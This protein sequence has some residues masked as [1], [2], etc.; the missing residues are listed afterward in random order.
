MTTEKREDN[1]AAGGAAAVWSSLRHTSAKSGLLRG[2]KALLRINQED[3][4]DCPGC[5][6]PDPEHRSTVEFCENGAKAVAHEADIR[7]V[8]AA[9][10]AKHSIT[11]LRA[12]TDFWLEDQGRLVEPVIRRVG[13][14]HYQPVTWE[15]AFA[16]IADHLTGLEHPDQAIFYTSGRASNEAAF[17]YQLLTRQLGTNNLPDCS[18]MCHESSGRGLMRTLGVGKGTVQLEDFDHA[19]MIFVVGQN[20]GT[21]HPRMLSTLREASKRGCQIISINPLRERALVRFSHPQKPL[22]FLGASTPIASQHVAVRIGGDLAL[23]KGICKHVLLLDEQAGG[24]IVDR[25]FINQHTEGFAQFA[26]SLRNISDDD[27]VNGSGVS[28]DIIKGLAASYAKAK[29]VIICWAMGITQHRHA[30]GSVREIVNLLLLRGNLGRQGAG[31][32]PVRGHSNVQGDRTMGIYEAPSEVFLQ[33]MESGTQIPMPRHHG[34]D[35]VGAV[36]A[37]EQ[38]KANFFMSLGGNFAAAMSDSPRIFSALESCVLTV[39]VATKLNRT[40]TTAGQTS[41]ILPC[42]GRTE[43]DVQKEKKQ[44]VTVEN[45]MGVVHLSQGSLKPA[46]DQLRSEPWIVAMLGH[47][48]QALL[49]KRAVMDAAQGR[50]NKKIS[51]YPNAYAVP[52]SAF[53]DDYDL[54]RTWI[55]KSIAGFDDFNKRVRDPHGLLLDNAARR[56]VFNNGIGKALFTVQEIPKLD[57]AAGHL[58]L[59][60]LRSHDQFNTTIYGMHDRYRDVYARRDVIFLHADDM[61]ERGLVNEQRVAVISYFA[62]Q[63]RRIDGYACIPYDI[64]KGSAAMYFPEANPLVPLESVAEESGTPTS[65][66]VEISLVPL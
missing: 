4:F 2:T 28:L 12:Q 7:K 52:W 46:S 45:S 39:H 13:D 19:D 10:F 31:A 51:Q 38:G 40:H 44:F 17:L 36:Q 6:W 56:L 9:F 63:E 49:Q 25:D 65:K 60:T 1:R 26:E 15:Q 54:I 8:D 33:K 3:G 50:Q 43:L 29:A 16:V 18:N 23:F 30:V 66:F 58:V 37:I 11:S 57:V 47:H 35:A 64:P 59:M 53:S 42:L 41:I 20:P 22:E 5:A 34:Y 61:K 27:V 55:E 48:V 24:T 14:T 21:N 32:C 62:G